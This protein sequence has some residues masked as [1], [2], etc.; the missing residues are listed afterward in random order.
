MVADE[1][2]MC[3]VAVLSEDQYKKH[4][5]YAQKQAIAHFS[6]EVYVEKMYDIYKRICE[7]RVLN[8]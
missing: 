1:K 4:A 8:D 6:N 3:E 5:E 2:K 7:H